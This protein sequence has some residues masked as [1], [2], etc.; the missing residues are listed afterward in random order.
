LCP[1]KSFAQ[2]ILSLIANYTWLVKQGVLLVKNTNNG[3]IKSED[4]VYSS[5][6][7]YFYEQ[8]KKN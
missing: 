2:I 7:D 6:S 8:D 1:H 4:F 5:A 3:G